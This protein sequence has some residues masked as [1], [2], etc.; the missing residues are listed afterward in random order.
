MNLRPTPI[1]LA[2]VLFV[3]VAE[4]A[5]GQERCLATDTPR[6]CFQRLV[7]PPPSS[8]SAARQAAV[9]QAADDVQTVVA[10]MNSGVFDPNAPARAALKDLLSVLSGTLDT[11]VVGDDGTK[12]NFGYSLPVPLLGARRPLRLETTFVKPQLSDNARS[13]LAAN[14][15]QLTVLDQSLTTLDDIGLTLTFAP[16]SRRFGRD[17]EPHRPLFAALFLA[18]AFPSAGDAAAALGGA[19]QAAGIAPADADRTF[20]QSFAGETE[21]NAAIA[22]FAAAA[23]AALTPLSTSFSEEFGRL[24]HN[25]PQ[26]YVSAL[27]H[28][29]EDVVGPPEWGA[30]VTWEIGTQNLNGFYRGD[31]RDCGA[32]S[33]DSAAAARC[34]TALAAYMERTTRARQAGR[35]AL[36]VRVTGTTETRVALSNAVPYDH[37]ATRTLTYSATYGRPFA[38]LISGKEGRVDLRVAYDGKTSVADVTTTTGGFARGARSEFHDVP[39]QILPPP[40]RRITAALTYTQQLN[41]RL[42]I[43]V[44]VVYRNGVTY[45]GGDGGVVSPPLPAEPVAVEQEKMSVHVGLTYKVTGPRR[46]GTGR[47]C[48]CAR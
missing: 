3:T 12:L 10:S 17:V 5:T 18:A 24:L 45:F 47:D 31:G 44:S 21:R 26:L 30:E 6:Q 39:P 23:G 32:A 27:Y 48:C 19:L 46:V 34:R 20:A 13:A 40:R 36:S 25:Q 38:S 7:P 42:A 2:A 28:P 35:L 14:P 1:V 8:K 15:A 11:A 16:A 37:P 33:L 43:P 4:G 41:E 22:A 29:R 9:N